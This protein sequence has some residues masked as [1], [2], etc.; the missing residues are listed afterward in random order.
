M[1]RMTRR[2]LKQDE[3]R[4]AFEHYEA[5]LKRHYRQIAIA[6]GAALVAFAAV[7]GFKL[8]R[9]RQES[10]ANTQLA[11]ALRTFRAYVGTASPEAAGLDAQTFPTTQEK[12]K[13]ALDQF[14][15]VASKY[16]HQKAGTVALYHAGVCQSFLGDH[17]AATKTLRRAVDSSDRELTALSNLALAGELVNQG[18]VAEA[19][20]IYQQLADHPTTTVPKTTALLALADAER[21]TQPAQARRIYERLQKEAGSNQTLASLL[22]DQIASLPK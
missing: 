18:K 10:A 1:D 9:E 13:K 21:A 14:F 2:Q 20:T 16:P 12:Y 17:A 3:L 15:E 7:A 11:V 5:F 8:Y 22:R 19:V 4:T 6:V